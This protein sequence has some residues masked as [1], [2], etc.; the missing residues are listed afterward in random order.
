MAEQGISSKLRQLVGRRD[1]DDENYPDAVNVT[2]PSK[3]TVKFVKNLDPRPR[4]IAE[5]GIYRG[6]TSAEF[7]RLMPEDGE[8]HLFDFHD[9]VDAVAADLRAQGF[10]RFRTFGNTKKVLDSYNW[11]LMEVLREHPEPIYDYVFID[12]AHTWQH[13][14][15]AFLLVDRLLKPGGYVD[16]D[17]YHWTLGGSPT[18]KPEVFPKTGEWYTREQVDAKQVELVVDL[19]VRRDP[20]YVEVVDNHIF[21]KTRA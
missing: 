20:R 3:H 16:F 8:L 2:K 12:G 10:D 15:F 18:L 13:D 17:D 11:S 19:L 9:A 1:P 14:G 6:H 4:R 7:A 21:Q 5:I